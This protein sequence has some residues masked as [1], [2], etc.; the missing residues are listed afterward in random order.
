[1][2]VTCFEDLEIWQIARR[3]FKFVYEISSRAEFDNDRKLRAQMRSSSGSM[4]DN[5]AEGFDRGG[6][7]EF[8]N[9]LSI[10]KASCGELRS[11]S[12]RS[13][14]VLLISDE[15]YNYLLEETDKFSSKTSRL[16]IHLSTTSYKGVK[17]D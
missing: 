8:R 14:D 4:A 9:F 17:Y 5:V 11:Q 3:L 1:M 6:N 10:A 12:Y 2:K 16:M 7:K 13:Y 15:E